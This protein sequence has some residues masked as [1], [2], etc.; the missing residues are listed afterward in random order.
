MYIPTGPLPAVMRASLMRVISEPTTGAEH[1]VP[2]TR[3]NSPATA[4]NA[5]SA[6]P[7]LHAPPRMLTH[8]VVGTTDRRSA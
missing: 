3:S 8:D 2:K 7:P 4:D 5:I 6:L 1:D